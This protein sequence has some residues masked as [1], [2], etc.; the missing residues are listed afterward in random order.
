MAVRGVRQAIPGNTVLARIGTGAGQPS[1]VSLTDLSKAIAQQSSGAIG[2][3]TV[4]GV[5]VTGSHGIT[6]S[7]SPITTS[8]TISLSLGATTPTSVA[9]SGAVSGTSVT[10]SAAVQ[11][12]TVKAT[13]VAGYIS[14]DGST[15]FTGTVTAGTLA[16]KT[17]T[18]KDG[19]IT[20]FA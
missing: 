2:P 10:A 20:G 1:P 8:G 12:A 14:S 16:T 5:A 3:G 15:G 13:S 4:T 18:I 7:G 11:G 19:I 17:I 9:A 6:V